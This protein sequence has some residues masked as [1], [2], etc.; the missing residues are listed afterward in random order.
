MH[1]LLNRSSPID[2]SMFTQQHHYTWKLLPDAELNFHAW[3]L[4]HWTA[5]AELVAEQ[6]MGHGQDNT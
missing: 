5:H 3:Q 2:Q 4:V 1:P 6:P